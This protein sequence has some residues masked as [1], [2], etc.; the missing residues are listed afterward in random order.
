MNSL[1][2]GKLAVMA[3]QELCV[4]CWVSTR[5]WAPSLLEGNCVMYNLQG[6]PLV[7]YR[8]LSSFQT[9]PLCSKSSYSDVPHLG[10]VETTQSGRLARGS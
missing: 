5:S 10:C 8:G 2:P 6:A 7:C 4:A 3:T 9:E 1:P